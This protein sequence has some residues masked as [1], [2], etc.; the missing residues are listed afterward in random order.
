M[1][2]IIEGIINKAL[3]LDPK[4]VKRLK[5]LDQKH[6][7]IVFKELNMIFPLELSFDT[8]G[9]HISTPSSK[10]FDVTIEGPSMAYLTLALTKDV[11]KARKSGLTFSGDDDV[12]KKIQ[13]LFMDLDI[14]W[15][16]IVSKVTGDAI[17]NKMGSFFKD[18]KKINQ[19]IFSNFKD[20]FRDYI[21]EERRLLPSLLEVEYFYKDI[22][23]L[24]DDVERVS[25][26]IDLLENLMKALAKAKMTQSTVSKKAHSM[27]KRKIK[28][29]K[30]AK[31]THKKEKMTPPPKKKG[32]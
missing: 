28:T 13:E 2:F 18:F 19:D 12:S 23:I 31:S 21:Q 1:F 14:D 32:S 17:A 3:F 27:G 24:R 16:E 30:N 9:V 10:K 6:V 29:S 4:T 25:A 8:Q 5:S 15:E 7:K 22:E 11:H 26:R 20:N